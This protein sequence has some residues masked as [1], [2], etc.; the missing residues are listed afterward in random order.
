MESKSERKVKFDHWLASACPEGIK[1]CLAMPGDASLRQYFRVITADGSYVAMDAPPPENCQPFTAIAGAL[2]EMAL[3]TPE[4]KA[5][6]LQN[7][8]LLLSD[9]GDQTYL[10]ALQTNTSL[11]HADHLY[12]LALQALAVMQTCPQV[13]GHIL[14]PFGRAWMEREWAWHQ[15][16][17]LQKWLGHTT[18]VSPAIDA[19]Y[20][21]LIVSALEQP[22]GF[23]HRD[24]HSANLMVLPDEK[25]GVLDFQDA[26]IGPV[27]YDVASLLR[28]CYIDW[29]PAQVREWALYY[30]RLI[31][32][33]V[34]EVTYM[35]WFDWMGLQRHLKAL[36]TFARKAVRDQQPRYLQH[37]PRTLNYI[38]NVS[39][40]YPEL[41]A[42]TNFY[43][44]VKIPLCVP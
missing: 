1:A 13:S 5:A 19:C 20:E 15:E 16:W 12:R 44:E 39:E 37:V 6:D 2:R 10:Q 23:M 32:L 9:F 8:F 31:K 11:A 36:M 25:V 21:Q 26:F 41:G 38:I 27:T 30:A 43:K 4:I 34:D 17:F 7:G 40:Q 3:V 18:V 22:H 24:F 33:E 35:R 14:Q 28:D 29:P 42:M